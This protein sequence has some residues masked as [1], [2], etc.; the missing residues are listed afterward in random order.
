MV[1]LPCDIVASLSISSYSV[2][3]VFFWPA[4]STYVPPRSVSK[5]L[6]MTRAP[7]R[8]KIHLQLTHSAISTAHSSGVLHQ[9]QHT[10]LP[11]FTLSAPVFPPIHSILPCPL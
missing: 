3:T 11:S 9:T 10:F 1:T 2:R 4:S 7:H 5:L 8:T 6:S